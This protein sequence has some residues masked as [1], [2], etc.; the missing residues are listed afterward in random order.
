MAG[1]WKFILAGLEL[2]KTLVHFMVRNDSSVL[3]WHDVWCCDHPLKT[4]YPDIFR[5]AH[6]KD[7]MVQEVISWNDFLELGSLELISFE[8]P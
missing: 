4:P 6:F 2:L 7:A 3:L 8:K 1:C 5:I